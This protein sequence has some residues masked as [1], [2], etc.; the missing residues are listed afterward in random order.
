MTKLKTLFK[1]QQILVV[2]KKCRYIHIVIYL[3]NRKNLSMQWSVLATMPMQKYLTSLKRNHYYQYNSYYS[4]QVVEAAVCALLS[5]GR[6]F[7]IL[8]H[9]VL[10][11][12]YTN[13]TNPTQTSQDD[14][15][16]C[17]FKNGSCNSN[18]IIILL[19]INTVFQFIVDS[20]NFK[21]L[22]AVKG[23]STRLKLVTPKLI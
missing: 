9:R 13:Y 16:D 17:N 10:I 14:A 20:H 7:L 8:L 3:F 11:D 22:V 5:G 18:H 19:E 21:K 6:R 2:F 23:L 12:E 1:M 15:L 4:P